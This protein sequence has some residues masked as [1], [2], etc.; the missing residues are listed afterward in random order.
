MVA[1]EGGLVDAL[2]DALVQE[3]QVG[4]VVLL[5]DEPVVVLVHELVVVQGVS[6][7]DVLV[8]ERPDGLVA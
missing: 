8:Q 4:L 1:L 7:V 6:L 5:E 3:R 2:V